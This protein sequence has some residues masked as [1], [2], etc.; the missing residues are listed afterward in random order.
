MWSGEVSEFEHP[1][2]LSLLNPI[3]FSKYTRLTVYTSDKM[4]AASARSQFGLYFVPSL[5]RT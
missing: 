2:L 5:T 4:L 1:L 3:S